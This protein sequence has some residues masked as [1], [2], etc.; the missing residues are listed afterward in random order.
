MGSKLAPVLRLFWLNGAV[1]KVR[2]YQLAKELGLDSKQ[3]LQLLNDRGEFVR[4][5]SSTI[6][7]PV[8]R[9][10][11]AALGKAPE[12]RVGPTGIDVKTSQPAPLR[13]EV[14]GSAS[15]TYE[16]AEPTLTTGRSGWH[17]GPVPAPRDRVVAGL[18]TT[19]KL[20]VP[21]AATHLDALQRLGSQ[22]VHVCQSRSRGLENLNYVR[23]RFSGAIE[24]G[25]G[26][27]RE[28]L[29]VYSPFVD[30]QAR[31]VTEIQRELRDRQPP[32]TPDIVFVSAPDP[33]LRSKLEDWTTP[34]LLLIPLDAPMENDPLAFIS[35]LRDY[36]YTRDLF[37][38]TTPVRGL[39]FFGRR[40]LLRA[41]RDD[42][43]SRSVAGVFGLRKA[44][45]TSV[46][47]EL[48][49]TVGDGTV[50]ILMDLETFPAP[51]D[52]PTPYILADLRIRFRDALKERHLRTMEIA[53]LPEVPSIT[54]WK[55]ATQV[56][57]K[58]L[59]ADGVR[60][61]L[62]LDEVEYL[63]SDKVDVAEGNLPQISQL[64]GAFRS[65]VQ[66]TSNFTF[67][68]SGLTSSI[69][70]SGRLYGRP[71]PLFSWAK[72]YYLGPF[73]KGEADELATSVG[74]RMGVEIDPGGLQALHDGSG[75]HAFLYRSL[76]SSAVQSLPKDVF[77][78]KVTATE[79][80]AAFIPW[81]RSIAGHVNDMI[82]HVKRYYP[83]EAFLLEILMEEPESFMELA[84]AEPK[85]LKHLLDLGLI[86]EVDHRY[87]LNSLLELM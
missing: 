34:D 28:V 16:L 25:F 27:T 6:E 49:D 46:M 30:L 42:V 33:R 7:P 60:V 10:L 75:G 73:D 58:K 83:T 77:G 41:L 53:G 76:A 63:T 52:D 36:L 15:V 5:A 13:E 68:L 24:T 85:E 22:F 56:L 82:D 84:E 81:K 57:L 44:G 18:I 79:V 20:Q 38:E 14:D 37:Y 9:R 50:P 11:L 2:V 72:S 87:E 86:R 4:S 21:P 67:L 66:E 51:P 29:F 23:V 71:N 78:R 64:L 61:L 70:E 31:L 32:V 80:Q 26:F 12:R 59:D 8:V 55:S 43:K 35:L 45:K 19:L 62:M 17:A 47:A 39:K 65:L 69:T 54:Q 48:S 1:A 74:S 40:K 3:L